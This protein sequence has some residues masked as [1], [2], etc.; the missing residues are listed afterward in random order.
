MK[1]EL[2]FENSVELELKIQNFSK[3]TFKLIEPLIPEFVILIILNFE[4]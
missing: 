4:Q 2:K 3:T 1:L